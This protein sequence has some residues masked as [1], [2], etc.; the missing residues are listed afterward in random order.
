MD[1]INSGAGNLYIHLARTQGAEPV[2]RVRETKGDQALE[3][4]RITLSQE[5]LL[6]Q[7]A[8]EVARETPEVRSEL[9]AELRRRIEEGSYVIDAGRIAERLLDA[10]A[11]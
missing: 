1:K 10:G 8:V 2:G 4:D 7:K 6:L 5:A 3:G 9:V 11:I